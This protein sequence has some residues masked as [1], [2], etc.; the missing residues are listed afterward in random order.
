[1]FNDNDIEA[2]LETIDI[3]YNETKHLQYMFDY[4]DILLNNIEELI[5]DNDYNIEELLEILIDYYFYINEIPKYSLFYYE[6]DEKVVMEDVKCEKIQRLIDI[7][8]TEQRTVEWL[9]MRHNMLS[10]SNIYRAFKSPATINSLIND[11]STPLAEFPNYNAKGGLHNPMAW[12]TLFERVSVKIYECVYK[13]R[14]GL[15]GCIPH[16]KWGFIGASPDGINISKG[17]RF[18]R[19]LE[20][21]NIYNREITGIPKDEYWVQMQV[22][23]EVCDLPLCDFLETRFCLYSNIE[24]FIKSDC[25]FRGAL[26]EIN[27]EFYYYYLWEYYG[28]LDEFM[29][30]LNNENICK[31]GGI[32]HWWY[33][34]EFSC[35]L[36]ERNKSWFESI[37]PYLKNTWEMI[38]ETRKRGGGVK[39]N[40]ICLIKLDETDS[41]DG[42]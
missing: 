34:D 31:G 20:I 37:F 36:V 11:K 23:M 18:G 15:F 5:I 22:Q 32:I 38:L 25:D 6:L 42:Q 41:C 26:I 2:I 24:E 29:V 16:N 7:P 40:Q 14:V 3:Y 28:N 30:I 35:V 9:E 4:R 33:L 10:A 27:G 39:K 21:K 12:G 8:I 1:M 13:T 19:M 17:E